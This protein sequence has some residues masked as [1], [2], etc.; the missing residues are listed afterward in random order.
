[1]AIDDWPRG[2]GPRE[3]LH[4]HGPGVLSDAELLAVVLRT[5]RRGVSALGLACALLERGGDLAGVLA[6]D[7]AA[8]EA[9]P[10]VGSARTQA[11]SSARASVASARAPARRS[12]AASLRAV[13][14]ER[15][16][17]QMT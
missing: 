17:I 10:G 8:L 3:K 14:L 4:L 2:E 5:G 16:R 12:S 9:E 15:R 1:M 13:R 11:G 7:A 6:M